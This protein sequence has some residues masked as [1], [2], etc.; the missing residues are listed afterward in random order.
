MPFRLIPPGHSC[1]RAY[2]ATHI[3]I[4]G[5]VARAAIPPI[6]VRFLQMPAD[7]RPDLPVARLRHHALRRWAAIA[8]HTLGA[9]LAGRGGHKSTATRCKSVPLATNQG[10][11]P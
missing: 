6:A 8:M 4:H 1:P 2:W 10:D 11:R 9:T 5:R 7:A 3:R